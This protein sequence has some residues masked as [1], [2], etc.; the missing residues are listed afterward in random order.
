MDCRVKPGNDD[1]GCVDL[2]GIR[3]GVSIPTARRRP[4]E[5][6]VNHSR[7][8]SINQRAAAAA[9]SRMSFVSCRGPARLIV[10]IGVGALMLALAVP[11]VAAQSP[12]MPSGMRT[13]LDDD[14]EAPGRA[15]RPRQ[16]KRTRDT[17]PIGQVPTF[18]LPAGSGAGR[19]GFISTKT[20]G[21]AAT[22]STAKKTTGPVQSGPLSLSASGSVTSP[23]RSVPSDKSPAKPP[24][25]PAPSP[26]DAAKSAKPVTPPK[27][28]ALMEREQ[29]KEQLNGLPNTV[30]AIPRKPP[31]EDPFA[32]LG[33]R[34]GAFVLRPAIETT[35][36]YDSNPG[37]SNGGKGSAF[38]TPAAELQARSD[39]LRHELT[40]EIRGA[41][42]AYE[43]TPQLDGP[44][45]N[46]KVAGRVDVTRDTR[47]LLEGRYLLYAANPGTPGLPA[48]LAALPIVTQAGATVGVVQNFNRL[49]WASKSTFDRIEWDSSKL[50]DGST[51]SNK[52]RNYNQFGMQDRVSYELTPGFKPFVDVAID[53]R[54]YD[55]FIDAGG[56][57][58]DSN[59]IAAK[60]GSSFEITRTLVGEAA[61]GYI[62]RTYKDPTLPDL[63]GVLYDASLL[64]AATGLTNVKLSVATTAQETSLVGV[65]GILSYDAGLQVDHAFRRWLIG[66]AR[67]SY[68][69]DEFVG[70]S[71]EDQRYA[72]SAA[73]TY[74]LTRTLQVKGE[75]R[76]EGR[77]SNQPG[78]DYDATIGLIGL[79]WQP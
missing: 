3:S 46:A 12:A 22:R 68:G 31:E 5:R 18:S 11:Q 27:P 30:V 1:R 57:H 26:K 16:P 66:T 48:D 29:L 38:V 77:R 32:P 6:P 51:A 7:F 13:T 35:G 59:G 75:V 60:A 63:R 67:L 20:K 39:W 34:A 4:D 69:L 23:D 76:R 56:V 19:T 37:R 73:L 17:A 50:T 21:K 44:N 52:G 54:D 15:R 33:V 79:R 55:L 71:R 40:A 47:V 9:A 24:A 43:A 61:I 78:N 53:T 28:P 25:T 45:L 64:W 74:K 8:I 2:L 14:S 72:A 58:R 62:Q 70:S 42:T 41:Y 49:E 10:P 65:S 36:G